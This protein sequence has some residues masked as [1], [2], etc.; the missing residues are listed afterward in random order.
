MATVT[1]WFE[2]YSPNVSSAVSFYESVFGW[3][4]QDFDMGGTN[5]PMFSGSCGAAFSGI[6]DTSVPPMTDIPPH[7]GIYLHTNNTRATVEKAVELGGT[8]VYGPMDIPGV[9][10]VAGFQD[11]CGAHINVHQPAGERQELE[12][13]PVNWIEH[14]GPDRSAAL[15]FY[16]ELLGY[17]SMDVPMEGFTYSMFTVNGETVGGCMQVPA[18][19]GPACWAVY[20][21]SNNLEETCEKVTAAGG[22]IIHAIH[23]IGQFGRIAIAADCCGAVFGLHQPP[24]M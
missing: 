6:M 21:H 18:E 16:G 22:S 13:C 23:D 4:H 7:W 20:F 9:G 14:M 24:A 11:C 10:T 1:N 8:L 5:Y 12:G 19:Q 17:G 3:K 15:A 2:V